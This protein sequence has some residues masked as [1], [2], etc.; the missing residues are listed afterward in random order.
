MAS[1]PAIGKN[2]RPGR[3]P[4][5]EGLHSL[6]AFPAR[7]PPRLTSTRLSKVIP[8]GALERRSIP[9]NPWLGPEN[10]DAKQLPPKPAT[11]SSS[12]ILK[13]AR[14]G[15]RQQLKAFAA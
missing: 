7:H 2:R 8:T 10:P 11:V 4:Y 14:A 6:P 12:Q 5:G 15:R 3:S 1:E 9:R 13:G